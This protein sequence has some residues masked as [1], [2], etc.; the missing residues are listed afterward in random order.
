VYAA[1]AA[2][3]NSW[4]RE[5]TFWNII[6]KL[7][8]NEVE[9]TTWD[10]DSVMHYPFD[11]GLINMPETYRNGLR[12][13]GGLSAKDISWAKALYPSTGVAAPDVLKPGQSM[14]LKLTAG[15][16]RNFT[17]APTETR[18]YNFQTF[19]TSDSVMVLF[20][21]DNGQLRFRTGDDDSGEDAN[22]A[23]RVKLVRGRK[24]V[25]RIRLYYADRPGETAVMMW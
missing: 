20:E 13:A 25:L 19:G 24:Y 15:Q 6:R 18:Y 23:F 21:D 10:P 9:G 1:L 3:P 11:P 14:L 12:P 17:I 5:T 16:Q 7:P 2:P 4:D 22:A 8:V